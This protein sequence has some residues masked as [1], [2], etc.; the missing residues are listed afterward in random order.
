MDSLLDHEPSMRAWAF[1]GPLFI[2]LCWEILAPRRLRSRPMLTR[3]FGNLAVAVL[4]AVALRWLFPILAL[5]LAVLAQQ[6]EWGLFNQLSLSGPVIVGV[7]VL[8]LDLVDYLRHRLFHAI[9]VCWRFHRMHHS[10]QDVD[11]STGLRFH[12]FEPA[13]TTIVQLLVVVLV[14][15]PPE[16]VLLFE[17][18]VVVTALFQHGNVALPETVDRW[19]RRILITPDM[20]R[21]HHSVIKKETDSNFGVVFPWWD[22][23]LGTYRN[24]P[25]NGHTQM[26]VG[27]TEFSDPRHMELHWMLALPFLTPS[28]EP[29]DESAP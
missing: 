24:Q 5:G 15:T 26:Q 10:D 11:W 18:L 6:R 14:G 17:L 21:V 1:Y 29:P 8:V 12:P 4:N 27:L 19:L 22:H 16:S 7:S 23:L 28:N 2:V 13:V 9:P 20:H 25:E 3:W